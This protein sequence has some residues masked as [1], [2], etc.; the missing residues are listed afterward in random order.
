ME[1]RQKAILTATVDEYIRSGEPVGSKALATVGNLNVSSA[2]IRSQLSTLE[3]AGFVSRVHT[4]SGRVPTDKGYR[5]YVDSLMKMK[6]TSGSA[7]L[8]LTSAVGN[9]TD[10]V[11]AV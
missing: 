10:D 9:L 6:K 11:S 8:D 2:T 1:K 4:S 5:F 3:E 7:N